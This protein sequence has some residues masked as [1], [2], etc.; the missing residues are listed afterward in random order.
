MIMDE[1]ETLKGKTVA[2]LYNGLT[3]QGTLTGA[4]EDEVFLQTST[5]WLSLPMEGI[6][7][8]QEVQPRG[9]F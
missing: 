9:G 2:V 4:S 6:T 7:E 3:Y 8:L 1:L 5:E